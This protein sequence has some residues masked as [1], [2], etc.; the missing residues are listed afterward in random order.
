MIVIE[1]CAG[2]VVRVASHD[3]K[4]KGAIARV[5]EGDALRRRMRIV[6]DASTD[7]QSDMHSEP[8]KACHRGF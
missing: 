3:D 6:V 4:L 1:T 7:N 2:R 5:A 8:Q